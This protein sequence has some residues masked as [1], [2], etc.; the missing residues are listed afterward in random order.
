M[1]EREGIG[2]IDNLLG[3]ASRIAELRATV[4]RPCVL[5]SER[6]LKPDGVATARAIF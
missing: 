2:R 3:T 5:V 6:S 4:I 1:N